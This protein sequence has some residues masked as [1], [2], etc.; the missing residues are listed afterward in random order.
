MFQDLTASVSTWWWIIARY[1]AKSKSNSSSSLITTAE[2]VLG[3]LPWPP[4]TAQNEAVMSSFKV[5]STLFVQDRRKKKIT[6]LFMQYC[7]RLPQVV[8][9]YRFIKISQKHV[10]LLLCDADDVILFPL[11]KSSLLLVLRYWPH[12][13]TSTHASRLASRLHVM[14]QIL[15]VH[16]LAFHSQQLNLKTK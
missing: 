2:M 3:K 11:C 12:I 7:T 8:K 5:N 13:S 4:Q 9:M 1:L 6:V 14:S 10:L 16:M 15:Q